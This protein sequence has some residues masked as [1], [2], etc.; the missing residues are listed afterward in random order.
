M[1]AILKAIKSIATGFT[2]LLDFLFGVIEDLV[3]VVKILGDA[4]LSIPT[5][6]G[7][8]PEVFLTVVIT[9]FGIVVIYKILGRE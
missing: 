9:I 1:K 2:S 6:L 4:I 8:L 5:Y 3:Y 7:W